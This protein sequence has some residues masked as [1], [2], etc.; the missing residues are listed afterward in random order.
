MLLLLFSCKRDIEPN[1]PH[2]SFNNTA[3][4]WFTQIQENDSLV[5]IGTNHNRRV[6][7]VQQIVKEKITIST[8]SNFYS[9]GRI[10]YT[11]D[12]M[13]LYYQRM[14]SIPINDQPI[15]F[16]I[17]IGMGVP[18]GIDYTRIPLNVTP[19]VRVAGKFES[20]N[21]IP[22]LPG[23]P[24]LLF[25]DVNGDLVFHSYV[26]A[27]RQYNE[28]LKLYSNNDL[29]YIDP[30]LNRSYTVNEVWVDKKYGF[31]FFKDIYGTTWSRVN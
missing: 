8:N 15:S 5:F 22:E 13:T 11:A 9:G 7:K 10:C 12:R 28:V 16:H 3:R 25:P 29:V 27:T 20:Y 2:F 18:D 4:E 31:V 19:I 14:D 1:Y 24:Y 30:Y 6:Y 23:S 17:V 21:R 26:N